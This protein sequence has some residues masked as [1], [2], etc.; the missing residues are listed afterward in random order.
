MENHVFFYRM[1]QASSV[2]GVLRLRRRAPELLASLATQVNTALNLVRGQ[3]RRPVTTILPVTTDGDAGLFLPFFAPSLQVDR[4]ARILAGQEP[5]A[6]PT[7]QSLTYASASDAALQSIP[8]AIGLINRIIEAYTHPDRL[9]IIGVPPAMEAEESLMP[10]LTALRRHAL[11][12]PSGIPPNVFVHLGGTAVLPAA[13]FQGTSRLVAHEADNFWRR[14][15][16]FYT[17]FKTVMLL[18]E[19]D[20][21]YHKT[22]LGAVLKKLT[23]RDWDEVTVPDSEQMSLTR[24]IW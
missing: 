16:A 2:A 6:L 13:I 11:A 18:R 23:G 20:S 24:Y 8:F 19:A 22:G 17:P 4:D 7:S 1:G 15:P 12:L 14:T 21:L 5:V 9:L 3:T 10:L